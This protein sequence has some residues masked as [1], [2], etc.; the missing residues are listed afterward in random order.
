MIQKITEILTHQRSGYLGTQK[1]ANLGK[2]GKSWFF[3]HMLVGNTEMSIRCQN[4]RNVNF[5]RWQNVLCP[6][7]LEDDFTTV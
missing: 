1:M 2:S 7:S 3:Q 4:I 5:A 6:L